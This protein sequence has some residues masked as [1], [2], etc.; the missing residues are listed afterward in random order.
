[1][2][3]QYW[4]RGH[5]HCRQKH[6]KCGGLLRE[7]EPRAQWHLYHLNKCPPDHFTARDSVCY[8]SFAPVPHTGD[9]AKKYPRAD[10][11]SLKVTST[12]LKSADATSC[13][14]WHSWCKE[15]QRQTRRCRVQRVCVAGSP[16][17]FR[18]G[19]Q[20]HH[21]SE[22]GSSAYRK[23]KHGPL[24]DAYQFMH[25]LWLYVT[26]QD[27][28]HIFVWVQISSFGSTRSFRVVCGVDIWPFVCKQLVSI[29][30][31]SLRHNES[32][33]VKC[34]QFMAK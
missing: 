15:A 21:S 31:I 4:I 7:R 30:S 18:T 24:G 29:F 33:K 16:A 19:I 23:G 28:R 10:R 17:P 12:A 14:R 3:T 11:R 34:W 27:A 5:I 6:R 1:M 13:K 20:L 25:L 2:V 8:N 32:V 26:N 22:K 9:L